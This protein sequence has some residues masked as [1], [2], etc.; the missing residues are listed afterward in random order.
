MRTDP[1]PLD[2]PATAPCSSRSTTASR[3]D[4]RARAQLPSGPSLSHCE[5]CGRRNSR[6][7]TAGDARRACPWRAG[8]NGTRTGARPACT[9]VAAARTA[10]CAEVSCS[11]EVRRCRA[12]LLCDRRWRY[13][14]SPLCGWSADQAVSKSAGP[15][16][17]STRAAATS[18]DDSICSWIVSMIRSI[19]SAILMPRVAVACCERP[20]DLRQHDVRHEP[21]IARCAAVAYEVDTARSAPGVVGHDQPD[22][23]IRINPDHDA[24]TSRRPLE[25]WP[26]PFP[27]WSTP[28]LVS[29][30]CRRVR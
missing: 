17:Y 12:S 27:R 20:G 2:G 21:G 29:A 15:A 26:R 30:E 28:A 9:T 3:T 10:S 4:R 8:K 19:A 11:S 18:V 1:W 7:A 23:D 6:A 13:G 16:L 14:C 25:R 22:Q 5:E 24:R